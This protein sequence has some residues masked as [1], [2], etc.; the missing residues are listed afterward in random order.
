[1]VS[2]PIRRCLACRRPLPKPELARVTVA[3]GAVVIDPGARRPGRGA[4]LCARPEC[5]DAALRRGGA[6][7]A[8]ALRRPGVTLDERALRAGWHAAHGRRPAE[9]LAGSTA[10]AGPREEYE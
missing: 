4:Y 2:T 8:R 10:A 7:V 3:D 1:M 9:V 6:A 5:L